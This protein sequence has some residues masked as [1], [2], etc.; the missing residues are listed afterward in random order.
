MGMRYYS[1]GW[2]PTATGQRLEDSRVYRNG[3]IGHFVHN[4]VNIVIAGG[5]IADHRKVTTFFQ[6]DNIRFENVRVIGMSEEYS[7]VLSETN[8]N[9]YCEKGLEMHPT[10]KLY[11][12]N[13]S[14]CLLYLYANLSPCSSYHILI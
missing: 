10:R 6:N 13:S 5:F 12:N 4:N 1:P 7:N 3:D 9:F 11:V 2:R 14:H 8:S